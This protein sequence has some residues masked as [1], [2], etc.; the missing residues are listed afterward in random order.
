MT[1]EWTKYLGAWDLGCDE[2]QHEYD[3]KDDSIEVLQNNICKRMSSF[4]GSKNA[5]V[6]VLLVTQVL[7]NQP[8][9]WFEN[10]GR[11]SL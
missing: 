1:S 10:F 9:N 5:A 11:S 7:S 6:Q 8:S 4:W 2:V 3:V